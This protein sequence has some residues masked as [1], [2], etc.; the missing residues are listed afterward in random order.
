VTAAH[1]HFELGA[2]EDHLRAGRL[3]DAAGSYKT[4]LRSAGQLPPAT[5]V[6][7]FSGWL[8]ALL[9]LGDRRAIDRVS[10][11]A[12]AAN[13]LSPMI[14]EQL[15]EHYRSIGRSTEA[16]RQ[17]RRALTDLADD[18]SE[19]SDEHHFGIALLAARMALQ[20]LPTAVHGWLARANQSVA[21]E[22]DA[23]L[24][25]LHMRLA[26]I[27]NADLQCTD[28]FGGID[29]AVAVGDWQAAYDYA[30]QL[31]LDDLGGLARM[32]HLAA[33]L[34][35]QGAADAALDV[36]DRALD[37]FPRNEP[38]YWLLVSVLMDLEQYDDALTAIEV[39][40]LLRRNRRLAQSVA[41]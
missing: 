4:C 24:V 18:Y 10:R 36:L 17:V 14:R 9:G 12:E 5:V 38:V 3:V 6:E 37:A 2:A 15:A 30:M 20:H 41:A 21:Q 40:Q 31:T 26:A 13:A 1:E 16:R 23:H 28:R 22:V 29:S 27:G 7:A 32:L 35:E 11:R 33:C 8:E 25:L 19:L 34:R 39:L